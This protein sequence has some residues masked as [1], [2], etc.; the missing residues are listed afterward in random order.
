MLP[1]NT[2]IGEQILA[3]GKVTLHD[4]LK[5][6]V[7]EST[8]FFADSD[9]VSMI[10]MKSA[11]RQTDRRGSGSHSLILFQNKAEH[12]VFGH[13]ARKMLDLVTP[14]FLGDM[15]HL[16]TVQHVM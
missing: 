12:R 7:M 3:G 6:S 5:R 1:Q 2:A 9:D 4:A 16:R 14:F 11:R 15:G 10:T 8:G 13:P